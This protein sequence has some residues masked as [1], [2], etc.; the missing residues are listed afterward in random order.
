MSQCLSLTGI[1]EK[2]TCK[3]LIAAGFEVM[4]GK[5]LLQ[6]VLEGKQCQ[7]KTVITQRFLT[8]SG[9]RKLQSCNL[10]KGASLNKRLQKKHQPLVVREQFLTTSN[11]ELDLR[12]FVNAF[13][14]Q[15]KKTTQSISSFKFLLKL[16]MFNK[17]VK[18]E[19]FTSSYT[20]YVFLKNIIYCK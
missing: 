8:I 10:P 6:K 15:K 14:K 11:Q 12:I 3:V 17:L 9:Q 20:V 7:I 5:V 4:Q 18:N 13:L 1:P 16:A 19:V 2:D